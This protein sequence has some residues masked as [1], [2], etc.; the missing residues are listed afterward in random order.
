M[1]L[2]THGYGWQKSLPDF[3][4]YL[5]ESQEVRSMLAQLKAPGAS[6]AALP[7]K[8]SLVPYFLDVADQ[9]YI[10]SSTAQACVDLVQYFDRRAWQRQMADQ[11][12]GVNGSDPT[13]LIAIAA[14]LILVALLACWL[15]ARKAAQVDPL[16][17]LR[18]D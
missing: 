7:S 3:R 2:T 13:T 4:D 12:Y 18:H 15:P 10:N 17:A 14:V 6:L 11:L 9:G 16:D 8:E 1:T 5:P